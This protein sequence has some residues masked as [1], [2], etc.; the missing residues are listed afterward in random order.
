VA[1]PDRQEQVNVV[2]VDGQFQDLPSLLVALGLDERAAVTGYV[3]GENRLAPFG[4]PD[5]M[6]DDKMYSMFVALV[7]H[8]RIPSVD[9]IVEETV[10]G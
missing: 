4:T 7:L 9:G 10:L 3:A 8:K 1:G 2:G 5:E 6:I